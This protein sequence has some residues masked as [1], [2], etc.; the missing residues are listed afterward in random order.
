MAVLCCV[1]VVLVPI[2]DVTTQIYTHCSTGRGRDAAAR[3]A[4]IILGL[5]GG[6]P[7]CQL[8]FQRRS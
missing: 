7:A 1:L 4:S 3:M 6:E 8:V 5:F 2:A